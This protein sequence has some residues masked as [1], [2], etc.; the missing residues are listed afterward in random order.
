MSEPSL[1]ERLAAKARRRVVVPVQV[2]DPT[3]DLG[4]AEAAKAEYDA[5]RVRAAGAEELARLA[6]AAAVAVRDV[7]EH[8]V[9][10]AFTAMH[11]ADFNAL[12]GTHTRDDGEVD[13]E[14]LAPQMLAAC[15]DD[16][17]LRDADWWREVLASW[18]SGEWLSLY[19]AVFAVNG[20]RP[21]AYVPKD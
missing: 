15:A 11:R 3:Q 1:R 19:S 5:A 8:Y 7:A 21:P 18:S 9:S 17:S 12:V 4:H 6:H 14:A 10:A 13:A 20:A 2:S 16:E